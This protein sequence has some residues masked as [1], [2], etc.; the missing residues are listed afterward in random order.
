MPTLEDAI[1]LAAE[2]HRGQSEKAGNPYI[3]HPLRVM[4]RLESE[5]DRIVG[6]LHDVIEDTRFTLIDLRA[7]GYPE[8]LLQALDCLTRR[9]TETYEEFIT[10]V[11]TNPLASRVKLAD[12]EDNMDVRRLP[13][14]SEKDAERLR[15]YLNAWTLLKKSIDTLTSGIP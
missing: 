9:E 8:P 6:V 15:K 5:N 10:R 11:R 14:L 13:A 4:F 2:A 12:L 1:L 3:L 7:M